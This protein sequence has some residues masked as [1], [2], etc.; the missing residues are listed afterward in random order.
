M[1]FLPRLLS[2]WLHWQE[3]ARPPVRQKEILC[4]LHRAAGA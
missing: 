2:D 3:L 4:V 1:L